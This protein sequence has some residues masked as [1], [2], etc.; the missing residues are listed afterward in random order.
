[1]RPLAPA[2]RVALVGAAGPALRSEGE[3]LARDL[4]LAGHVRR[5]PEVV[6][7][8]RPRPTDI[9]LEVADL[10][11][12]PHPE[13]YVLSADDGLRISAPTGAGVFWGT[14]SLVQLLRSGRPRGTVVDW[15]ELDERALMLDIGRKYWTPEWIKALIREMS[16]LKLNTLQLH[17][18]EGLGFGIESTRHPEIVSEQH[19]T[20]AEVREILDVARDHHVRVHPDVD[21]PAHLEHILAFHPEH[22]LVL[23]DGTRHPS[24]LDFSRP[25]ARTLVH[26]IVEEMCDLFDGGVFHLGGDEFFPAPWQGTG[27][28]VV[29]D[30]TAPQLVAYAREATGDPAATVFDGYEVYLNE[31]AD[32]VRARGY[33]PRAW[34]DDIYPGEGVTRLDPGIQADVW[35]RWNDTKPTAADYAAAGHELV[36]ANGDYLYFILTADGLGQGPHKNPRGIYERWTP[37]TF[38]GAAGSAG[39]FVLPAGTPMRGAHLSVWCDTPDAMTQ[40]QV[41]AELQE[42]LQVFAQQTWGSPRTA[43]TLDELRTQVVAVVGTAPA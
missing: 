10:P 23:A 36:N 13:G 16:Y 37:R 17:I 4:Q 9:V 18:S 34:N 6:V 12:V 28:D 24:H 1:G 32:L 7:T 27:D 14:R 30:R 11:E 8:T 2:A 3:L 40:E 15:P 41:A 26:E 31:L 5:R 35:I 21:T 42:W 38:M 20:K 29:S 39:D 22:Q 33:T 19:L 25:A 43:A